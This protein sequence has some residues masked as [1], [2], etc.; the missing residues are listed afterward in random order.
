MVKITKHT[1]CPEIADDLV[2]GRDSLVAQTV[3][4]PP[5]K[6]KKKESTCDAGDRVQSLDWAD[7]LE[8]GIATHFQ[9]SCLQNAMDRGAWRVTVHRF[10]KNQTQL[11]D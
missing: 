2:E 11:T 10:P 1:S 4:N 5:A 7:P 6:K 9:Y 8:E 3:K